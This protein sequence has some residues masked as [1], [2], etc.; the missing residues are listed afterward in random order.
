MALIGK[1]NLNRN[2]EIMDQD[3]EPT[4]EL[5][6]AAC[7][8][9]PR[10]NVWAFYRTNTQFSC[11]ALNVDEEEKKFKELDPGIVSPGGE[12]ISGTSTC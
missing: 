12:Y 10:C 7:A 1:F 5:C 8:V 6:Q 4:P 9:F 11:V 3:I 2:L